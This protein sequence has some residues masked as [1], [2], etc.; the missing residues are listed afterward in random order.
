MLNK[1][2]LDVCVSRLTTRLPNYSFVSNNKKT[3]AGR[4]WRVSGWRIAA[5]QRF[6]NR[7]FMKKVGILVGREKT[8]PEALIRNVNERGNGMVTAGYLTLFLVRNVEV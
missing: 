5:G 7:G 4:D 2:V 8:F 1:F 6:R 3:N